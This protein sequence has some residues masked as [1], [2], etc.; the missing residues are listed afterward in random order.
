MTEN[1]LNEFQTECEKRLVESLK[2][3]GLEL[4]ERRIK[5]DR[6]NM[7]EARVKDLRLWI[8]LDGTDAI[9]DNRKFELRFEE[10]DFESPADLIKTFVSE[11]NDYLKETG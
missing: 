6:F 4:T 1:P 9:S 5:Y 8:Y 10:L 2:E 11:I 3:I 7:V